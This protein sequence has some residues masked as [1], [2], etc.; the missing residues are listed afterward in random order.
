L[1]GAGGNMN[2]KILRDYEELEQMFGKDIAIF[3]AVVKLFG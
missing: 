2:D 3:T 1:E